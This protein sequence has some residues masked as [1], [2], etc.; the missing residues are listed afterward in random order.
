MIIAGKEVAEAMIEGVIDENVQVQVNGYDMTLKKVE[1]YHT[2]SKGIL[3]FDN[4]QRE[5]PNVSVIPF[6]FRDS[7]F[8]RKGNYLI[9][10][11]PKMD[12][13]LDC[14]GRLLPRSSLVR[15]GCTID[16]GVFDA[17]FYGRGQVML[18]VHNLAGIKLYKNARVAQMVFDRI[19]GGELE[20]GYNGI[21][22]E[23]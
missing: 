20:E 22:N 16:A 21:Y 3:D 1:G 2:D 9:T 7:V 11:D 5:K 8:L 14:I 19:E 4:S 12:I 6:N 18:T 15:M 13:P 17:G 10:L 23:A